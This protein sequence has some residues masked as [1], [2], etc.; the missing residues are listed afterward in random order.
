MDFFHNIYCGI[1]C[2][3]DWYDLATVFT[4]AKVVE[5][6]NSVYFVYSREITER[7]MKDLIT[8]HT[9]YNYYNLIENNCSI[10]AVRAWNSV[11]SDDKFVASSF[12][13]T[14]KNR[15]EDRLI[16]N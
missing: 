15:I 13:W 16:F 6:A 7:Q 5:N 11:F 1:A 2:C 3:G 4:L 14:L 10:V 12:P 9:S 8:A